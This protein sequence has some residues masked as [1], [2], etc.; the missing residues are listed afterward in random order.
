MRRTLS[1]I[2]LVIAVALQAGCA[3]RL[4]DRPVPAGSGVE[5]FVLDTAGRPIAH[6]PVEITTLT[7]GPAMPEE[8]AWHTD[9]LGRYVIPVSPGDRVLRVTAPGYVPITVAIVVRDTFFTRQDFI[10][11]SP[12]E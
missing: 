3:E 12:R 9:S 2:A 7:G 11:R 10:M 5:G 1:T 6:A 4:P 8:P